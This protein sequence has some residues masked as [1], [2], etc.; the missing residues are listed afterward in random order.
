[1]AL[2]DFGKAIRKARIDTG[3]TLG[4]MADAVG[5]TP[6]FLSSIETGRK[7]V[8]EG[9]VTQ[10][11]AFFARHGVKIKQLP[12][13]AAVAN[14]SVPL[15]G[16]SPQHQMLVAGFARSSLDAETL[17]KM[18]ALLAASHKVKSK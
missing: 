12:E 7:K 11:A 2:T 13:L 3:E 6:S 1:M 8:P 4:S 9:L 16:L 15:D 17:E 14:K 10:V 5:V 18:A